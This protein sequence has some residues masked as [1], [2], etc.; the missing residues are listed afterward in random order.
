MEDPIYWPLLTSSV[1][2]ELNVLHGANAGH[3]CG[4]DCSC[5]VEKYAFNHMIDT[6]GNNEIVLDYPHFLATLL[7]FS[8]VNF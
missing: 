5:Y 2:S 3:K 4:T 8:L 6:V 7:T 1:P